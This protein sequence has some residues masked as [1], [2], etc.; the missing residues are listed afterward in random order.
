MVGPILS[1]ELLIG[2]RRGWLSVIRRIYCGWLILQLAFF[3]FV[4]TAQANLLGN[5]MGWG[6][7][8]YKA[9]DDFGN[10]FTRLLV[11]QQLILAFLAAP[12]FAAGAITDEKLRGTLQYLLCADLTASEIVLGKLLGRITQVALLSLCA[13]PVICFVGV[14]GGINLVALIA[15]GIVT[16]APMI[17]LGSASMLASVWSKNTRDA[18][19]GIYIPAALGYVLALWLGVTDWFDPVHVLDPAWG[20]SLDLAEVGRRLAVFLLAWGAIAFSCYGDCR[21]EASFR[22]LEAACRGGK[23]PQ[24]TLVAGAAHSSSR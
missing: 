3:Y 16:V 12:A 22:I 13:L 7:I 19:L 9:V 14:F 18:V 17:A 2:S 4:Y 23:A 21:L 10:G 15:L 24:S 8:N 6:P 20:A 5:R 1:Q 11:W